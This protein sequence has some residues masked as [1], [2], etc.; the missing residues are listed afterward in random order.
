MLPSRIKLTNTAGCAENTHRSPGISAPCRCSLQNQLPSQRWISS[1][2]TTAQCDVVLCMFPSQ[3]SITVAQ[4]SRARES[5]YRT[6][7]PT[8]T[9]TVQRSTDTRLH[10]SPPFVLP[11]MAT[12]SRPVRQ[13]ISLF[14]SVRF[15]WGTMG[16]RTSSCAR[17]IG[18]LEIA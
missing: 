2:I 7:T 14:L 15:G 8:I 3:S 4:R 12:I 17:R 16:W 13:H 10:P 1:C 9:S 6:W 5:W 18:V 11:G